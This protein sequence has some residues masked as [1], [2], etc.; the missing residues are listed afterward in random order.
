[1]KL[2][3]I[4]VKLSSTFNKILGVSLIIDVAFVAYYVKSNKNSFNA[5]IGALESREELKDLSIYFVED[6]ESLANILEHTIKKHQKVIFGMSF[7]TTQLWDVKPIIST[8]KKK[9]KTKLLVI[10]GGAHPTGDP[11][12]TLHM[13][14]DIIVVGEGEE[15]LIELMQRLRNGEDS[16]GIKGIAYLDENGEYKYTGKRNPINLDDY[17]PFPYEHR[18]IGPIEIT[19]GCP[20]VCY[21]CQTPYMFGV[22]YR[23]RSVETI[24]QYIQLMKDKGLADIRFITPSAFAYGASDTKTLNIS[25]F[26]ELLSKSKA[27]FPNS[28]LFIGSFPSEVRPDHI[29]EKSL[30][31]LSKYASNDNIVI[32]AQSGSQ[33]M[34]DLCHRGHTV[35]DIYKAV[36]LSLKTRLKVYVD[37]IFGLPGEISEDIAQTITLMKDLTKKGAIMHAHAFIP[38]PQTPF[39]HENIQRLSSTYKKSAQNL[40]GKGFLFGDWKVQERLAIRISKYLRST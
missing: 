37:I 28:R 19:R 20:Y 6:K 35:Q 26:E 13:G 27:F 33:K 16:Y 32:G 31:L 22:H 21:F 2:V 29:S 5:L 25:K 8:L 1:M 38:L 7:F 12:G 24:L 36:D 30:A 15:T 10:A 40:I 17:R 14:F 23:H 3:S 39:A 18:K 11:L 34:L 9:F 4:L